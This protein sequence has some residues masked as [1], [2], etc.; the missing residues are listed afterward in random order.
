MQA[1]DFAKWE[2]AGNDFVLVDARADASFTLSTTEIERICDRHLGVGSDGLV[3]LR[4]SK[5]PGITYAMDFFNPDGTQSFCGNGSRCAFAFHAHLTGDDTPVRF[6]AVDGVHEAGWDGRN[7]RVGMR[8]VDGIEQLDPHTDLLDTGSPH[9]VRWVDDPESTDVVEEGRSIRNDRRFADAGVN[10]NF[11]HW[12]D[13]G[14]YMR[15]YERGVENETLSCGTGVTAAALSAMARG[16]G[17]GG[18]DVRTRGGA[19]RVEA[20]SPAEGRFERVQLIGPVREVFTGRYFLHK[21]K[22]RP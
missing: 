7:V 3:L 12:R 15:T 11:V 13:G 9:V 10:V 20:S 2:G 1:F 16:G 4:R 14:L 5:G 19:L 6:D 17:Q 22:E 8:S 21:V 18:V